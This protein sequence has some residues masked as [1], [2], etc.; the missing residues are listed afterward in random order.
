MI[1]TRQALSLRGEVKA[2]L[3]EW[4]GGAPPDAQEALARR[5]ELRR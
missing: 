2:I 1:S 3:K 4:Q 5:P